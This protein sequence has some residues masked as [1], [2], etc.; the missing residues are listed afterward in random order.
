MHAFPRSSPEQG[1][2]APGAFASPYRRPGEVA[3]PLAGPADRAEASTLGILVFV[4]VCAG[5]RFGLF[6]IRHEH[7]GVDPLLALAALGFSANCLARLVG[8]RRP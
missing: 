7:V 3:P 5:I 6:A 2:H 8:P 1:A 4:L